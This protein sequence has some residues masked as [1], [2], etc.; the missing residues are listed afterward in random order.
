MTSQP[1][2]L[3]P[4]LQQLVDALNQQNRSSR[5]QDA[6]RRK[7]R[8][9]TGQLFG[10][11]NTNVLSTFGDIAK[12]LSPLDNLTKALQRAES[13]QKQAVASYSSQ[14]KMSSIFS[15]SMKDNMG[16]PLLNL[17]E[18][19]DNFDAGIRI[20]SSN[21]NNL[22]VRMRLTGQSTDKLRAFTAKQLSETGN[23]T[24]QLEGVV[25]TTQSLA[26]QYAVSEQTLIEAMKSIQGVTDIASLY[27]ETGRIQEIQAN[28]AAKLGGNQ[29]A[30]EKSNQAMSL[31]LGTTQEAYRF[32]AAMGVQGLAEQIQAAKTSEEATKVFQDGLKTV[33]AKIQSQMISQ[34]GDN[35]RMITGQMLQAYGSQEQ[36]IAAFQTARNLETGNILAQ[37]AVAKTDMTNQ[38][39]NTQIEEATRFYSESVNKYYPKVIGSME[40]MVQTMNTAVMILTAIKAI[41]MGGNLVGNLADNIGSAGGAAT[42]GGRLV[43]GSVL[44]GNIIRGLS[45]ATSLSARA[46]GSAPAIGGLIAGGMQYAED[47]DVTRAVTT[48]A[49]TVGGSYAGGAIGA[50]IGSI[51]LPGIGT[52]VGMWAGAALGGWLGG[53]GAKAVH[54]AFDPPAK[55]QSEVADDLDKAAKGLQERNKDLLD[56]SKKTREATEEVAENT[57]REVTVKPIDKNKIDNNEISANKTLIQLQLESMRQIT[58]GMADRNKQQQMMALMVD[59]LA[60]ING[61]TIQQS[62]MIPSSANGG[63]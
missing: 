56:Q 6:E 11:M 3:V 1:P 47:Q 52:A 57:K 20:N 63:S 58:I 30:I 17:Q 22:T 42:A 61:K 31:L 10:M 53:E 21:L 7:E 33:S 12:Q 5:R 24:D 41:S 18:F 27:D 43:R 25:Q 37:E 29:D 4:V 54:D 46:L 23:N 39:F 26:K 38:L 35:K 19:V 36:I 32:Q 34:G 45:Q 15:K 28:L 8:G 50:T 13:I 49:G 55:K 16:D 62:S 40:S 48:G 44:N 59:H 9:L 2:N 51:L 14:A 60:S